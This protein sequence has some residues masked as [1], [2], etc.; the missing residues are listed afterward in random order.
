V[1]QGGGLLDDDWSRWVRDEIFVEIPY[2]VRQLS[3]F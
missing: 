1:V 3:V 2:M